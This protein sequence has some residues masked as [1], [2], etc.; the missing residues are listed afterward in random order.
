MLSVGVWSTSN[1]SSGIISIKYWS[2]Y[3]S[4]VWEWD[5]MAPEG[6]PLVLTSVSVASSLSSLLAVEEAVPL[7]HWVGWVVYWP[8]EKQVV[9][10]WGE[11]GGLV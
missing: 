11:G 4:V 8:V 1:H 5:G 2:T 7:V 3:Q 6:T 10:V 9:R